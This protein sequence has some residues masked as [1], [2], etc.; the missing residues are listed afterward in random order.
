[1]ISIDEIRDPKR[2]RA[3]GLPEFPQSL[4][5]LVRRIAGDQGR[6]HGADRNAGDPIGMEVRLRQRLIDAGLIGAERASALQQQRDALERRP[7]RC[8]VGLAFRRLVSAH[9]RD[10]GLLREWNVA[11]S[12]RLLCVSLRLPECPG[13]F[14]VDRENIALRIGEHGVPGRLRRR[15]PRPQAQPPRAARRRRRHRQATHME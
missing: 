3:D 8:N 15:G 1:M 11:P 7:L 5:A 10:F 13:V 2:R 4:D 14:L 6:V 9:E 12:L